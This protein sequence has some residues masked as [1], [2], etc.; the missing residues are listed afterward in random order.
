M[1]LDRVIAVRTDRTVYRDGDAC[2]KVY[3]GEYT[4]ADVLGEALNQALA[5]EAGVDVPRVLRVEQLAGKWALESDYIRGETL[6]QLIARHPE[7]AKQ[8]IALMAKLQVQTQR[9][10]APRLGLLK[11]R[12]ARALERAPLCAARRYALF[13]RLEGMRREES[14]CHGDF[15]PENIIMTA[16]GAPCVVDWESAAR[17]DS[18]VDAAITWLYFKLEMG[19]DAA[20]EYIDIY[21]LKSNTERQRVL[22]WAPLAAAALAADANARRR[23]R[24]LSF[25][26]AFE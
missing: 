24:L 11:E 13:A 15:N 16:R 18:A 21:C 25:G 19:E 6:A 4:R 26:D 12:L 17:G 14:L 10:R 1:R 2:I 3:G 20:R 23:E 5:A 7:K 9:R 8:Y 22:G